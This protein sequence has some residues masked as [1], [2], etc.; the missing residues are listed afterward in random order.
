[1][2]NAVARKRP[3][4]REFKSPSRDFYFL[5]SIVVVDRILFLT[6]RRQFRFGLSEADIQ[7]VKMI[8][9][10]V[11]RSNLNPDAD[12]TIPP[13]SSDDFYGSGHYIKDAYRGEFRRLRMDVVRR[14]LK[15]SA[16]AN[17][18]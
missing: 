13:I 15:G 8:N 6:A 17:F 11:R 18:R 5:T 10:W 16:G 9:A 4:G 2:L 3:I 7:M 14:V 1:M 12:D